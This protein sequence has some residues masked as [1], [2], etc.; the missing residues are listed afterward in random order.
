MTWSRPSTIA[1]AAAGGTATESAAKRARIEHIVRRGVEEARKTFDPLRHLL[2]EPARRADGKMVYR[3]PMSLWLAHALL[4]AA[5][6]PGAED[7]REAAAIVAAALDS[8]ERHP[9]HPHRGNFLWL[10]D[11]AEVVDL[12]AVQFMLRALLPLVL[13]HGH[14]L[15]A[16][17][18][19][20]ARDVVRLALE[21]QE[22]LAVAPPYTNIHLLALFSLLVGGEWLDDAHYAALGR[23]R[24]AEWVRFTVGS[25]APHE[26]NSPGYGA[27]DLSALAALHQYVRDPRVK[28][29]VRLMYERIWLHVAL[30]LHPPTGQQA[31]PHCRCYWPMMTRARP[32]ILDLLWRET[33]STLMAPGAGSDEGGEGG[34]GGAKEHLPASLEL[35]L[36]A[37]WVPAAVRLWLAHYQ[38]ALPAQVRETAN[39]EEG[40]DLTTYLTPS[41]ALGTA[42]HTYAIGQDDFYI[43]HQANYLALHYRR[44]R[45]PA[46][47]KGWGL[48]YSRYVVNDR[49]H[50]TLSA[51]PDR[52]KTMNFYDQGHFAGAQLGNKAIALYALMPQPEEVSS[53]KTVVV[54]PT[55]ETLD[56][57]WLDHRRITAGDLP[58][59]MS[60]GD[61][62]V[63]ADGA[64]YVGVHPL[65]P[66]CLGREAPTLLERGPDGELWLTIY[67]YRG[68][69]KRFW[70]YASLRGAF[71]RGNLRAGYLIEVAERQAYRSAAVFLA[72]LRRA[73]VE[74]VT[75]ATSESPVLRTVRYRSG[76]E[77]LELRYDLWRTRPAGRCFDG[78]AYVP[79]ALESPLAVQGAAGT[80]RAGSATLRTAA[81]VMVWLVSQELDPTV[82]CWTAV[83]PEDRSTPVRLET[84]LGALTAT[85]W[86]AGRI[87]W[88][89]T[90]DGAGVVTLDAGAA[91]AG[92][93]VPDG[94]R[95]ERRQGPRSSPRRRPRPAK[96]GWS[97]R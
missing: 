81:G 58:A 27:I 68:P 96:R 53:L 51:A 11:D 3:P 49:H 70:D 34:E 57:V 39:R 14:R 22:R 64:V 76:G 19:E 71:W 21:E 38:T 12:N 37:H 40:Q 62:L 45:R 63:V 18:L 7:A 56:E 86:K 43:E 78:A 66:S 29:Q 83:N 94:T 44:P 1:A 13:D 47:P 17:V 65:E 30:H 36:T 4:R 20:R 24:W 23:Q 9:H 35:A 90:G 25:G 61:W 6:P 48:V 79:P 75:A 32:A 88:R 89:T 28:R 95:V 50:G 33:G 97:G 85:A 84:P 52:P 8:Q 26:F 82:H 74:D 54:F 31:G 55:V 41:Y 2:A 69:A 77:T 67:N 87:Q 73:T 91:P 59:A 16:A 72:H 46:D 92:L 15:P 60:D 80:L 5:G 42:S 93:R 10:A